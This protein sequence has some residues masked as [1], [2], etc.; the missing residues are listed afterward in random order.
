MA[1]RKLMMIG[2]VVII[3]SVFL[4]GGY[5]VKEQIDQKAAQ[6]EK[7]EKQTQRRKR[8]SEK[9]A[10]VKSESIQKQKA[11]EKE[12]TKPMP[13]VV[14]DNALDQYFKQV[15]FSGTAL[16]VKDNKIMLNKGYGTANEAAKKLNTPDTLY[17]IASTEK[18]LIATGILQLNQQG[19]LKVTDP[20]AKYLPKFPNGQ[21]IKL[22][23]LLHH[24][25]GIVG[26][27]QDNQEKTS[28]QLLA[29]I[30]EN[31]TKGQPGSWHYL[32][33]NYIVLVKILEK[34]SHQNYQDYLQNKIIKPSKMM[35]TGFMSAQYPQLENASIGYETK[36]GVKKAEMLPNFSQ[37]YGVGDMYMT[38][39]DMYRFDK[40]LWTHKL[41]NQQQT[42]LMFKPGSDSHYGMGMYNDPALIVNR[43]YL[44]GWS[45]SNGFSHGGR[46]YIVLFSN[47]KNDKTSLS[48]MNSDLYSK[49]VA[50]I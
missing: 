47:V 13:T 34:V 39:M 35:H 21:Q 40:A 32:D 45:V 18:A 25:S 27:N 38:A 33:A 23:D 3:L 5:V 9:A 31:G 16:I 6:Q 36:G 22:T 12:A 50:T 26:R 24:T 42:D 43:G 7:I 4:A 49:V 30:I 46:I 2:S 15:N 14:A 10:M 20:V 1:K 19:K 37:L 11:R 17:P 29:E 44:S 48:K 8:Q 28:D 41:I